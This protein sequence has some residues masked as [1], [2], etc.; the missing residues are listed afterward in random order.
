[1]LP[2]LASSDSAV[3]MYY[4]SP[5]DPRF[6]NMVK[7]RNKNPLTTVTDDVNKRII[8]AKDT[9][10][11]Q[12]KIY[13]YGKAGAVETVYFSRNT[14]CLTLS[15]I[16]TGE[17]YFT[18]MSEQTKGLLDSLEKNVTILPGRPE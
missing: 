4:H 3:V 15:F 13:F 11:T 14:D 10:T 16:K 2:A 17:K 1:M 12:G 18:Q 7:L 9:C 5:G 8:S 6:F